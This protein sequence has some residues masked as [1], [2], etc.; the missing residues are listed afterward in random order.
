MLETRVLIMNRSWVP[1][2]IS[3]LKRALALLFKDHAQIVDTESYELF[4]WEAWLA[5]RS[6]PLTQA[7]HKTYIKTVHLQIEIPKVITLATYNRI[8]TR[9][10]SFSKNQLFR[11]DQNAC[12]YCGVKPGVRGLTIDHVLPRSRGGKT[13][14]QN[15]VAS[16]ARCNTKKGNKTPEEAHLKLLNPPYQPNWLESFSI[17]GAH[18][19]EDWKRFMPAVFA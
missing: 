15:C 5:E 17:Q 11:R 14:W 7:C 12:Q 10:L 2:A 18:F 16:C 6:F 13:S 4:S 1:V 9:K 3:P 8:P 19:E